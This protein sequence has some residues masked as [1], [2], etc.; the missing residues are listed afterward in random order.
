MRALWP[1]LAPGGRLVYATCS[2]LRRENGDQ[3]AA[4][5]AEEPAIE[6]AEG[7]AWLQLKP[8]EAA[9]DGF[10]YAWLQK[11]RLLRTPSGFH[12]RP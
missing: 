4:F 10:Y 6:P 1:L 5:R 3:I 11:P 12:S 2:G 7:V 8:G 9:G